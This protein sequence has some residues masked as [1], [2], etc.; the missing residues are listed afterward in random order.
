MSS[1]LS[2]DPRV[3]QSS[4]AKG[5]IDAL[6]RRVVGGQVNY[7]PV[8]IGIVLIWVVLVILTDGAFASPRNLVNLSMQLA[9][10][11]TIALGLVFVLLLGEIDLSAGAVSGLA[12][13]VVGVTNVNLGVPGPLAVLLAIATGAAVGA[14]QGS[15][16]TAF[17][18]PAF[19]VTLAG[20]LAWDGLK[21]FVLGDTGSVNVRDP[22]ILSFTTI[23]FN[24]IALWLIGAAL[25]AYVSWRL[26]GRV[27]RRRKAGLAVDPIGVQ[28]ILIAATAAA[29]TA[30]VL[31]LDRD[32]GLSLAFLVLLILLVLLDIMLQRTRVGRMI[33]AIG[34]NTASAVRAGLPVRRVTIF[35]FVLGSSLAAFGG[36]IATSR[37]LAVTQSA[38]TA[39][40][41]LN[42]IAAVVIGGTSLFGGRGGVWSALLGIFVIQSISNGMDLL[43]LDISIKLLVT[44]AV[45]LLA[46]TFDAVTRTQRSKGTGNIFT[47]LIG[48]RP[49]S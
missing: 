25:V 5:T 10:T 33:F 13:A 3:Q 18:V 46:V 24:G 4:G 45:L 38:G 21:L 43:S 35:V 36:V 37:S 6:R 14:F 26:L 42:A 16:I 32:R 39:E 11:G 19:I 48:R 41:L 28:I 22:F 47:R 49:T 20:L 9:A 29:V 17:R 15:W 44:G 7:V 27:A 23:F 8:I 31:V 12:A 2:H 30:V 34:G 40:V 1:T